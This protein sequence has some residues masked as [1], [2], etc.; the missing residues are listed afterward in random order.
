MIQY[1]PYPGIA[2]SLQQLT[3]AVVAAKP[4]THIRLND[5]EFLTMFGDTPNQKLGDGCRMFRSMGDALIQ[6]FR[7]VLSRPK[8]ETFIGSYWINPLYHPDAEYNQGIDLFTRYVIQNGLEADVSDTRWLA[9]DFWYSTSAERE[10][11]VDGGEELLDLFAVVKNRAKYVPVVLVGNEQIACVR[12]CLDAHFI[13]VPRV[14]CWNL[15]PDIIGW[16]REYAQNNALFVWCAGVAA[17]AIA[18]DISRVYPKTSHL[19]FGSVFDGV[20]GDCSRMW[21]E[22]RSGPHWDFLQQRIVPYVLGK[23][24]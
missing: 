7:E 6:S 4:F 13:R 3:E 9:G 2:G 10:G 17:K 12:H 21:L 20:V 19:D 1:P 8:A 18:V 5:G 22:R 15:R 14:D 24:E 11:I 23:N 16:C